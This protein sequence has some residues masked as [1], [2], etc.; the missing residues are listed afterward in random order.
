MKMKGK[1]LDWRFMMAGLVIMVLLSS[2][3][4]V[5][6]SVHQGQMPLRFEISFTGN[7]ASEMAALGLQVP[8]TGRLFVII[9]KDNSSEP[10][11]QINVVGVPFWGKDVWNISADQTIAITGE[12]ASA[13]GYPL[14][15]FADVPS[16]EY[17]VQAF[18]NVYT[19]FHRADGHVIK[20]HLNSGAGQHMWRSP[21]NAYSRTQRLH[22]D[23]ES[24][25]TIALSLSEVIPPNQPLKEG[26]VL[27]Q[28]NYEDTEWVKYVKIKSELVSEFWGQDMYI[29]ANILLPKGYHDHP[30]VYYPVIYLQG[31]FPGGWA[32]FG[33]R[34]G[35]FYDFWTSD[36][37]PRMIAVTFRHANPYYDSSY[38]INSANVGPYGDAI[39]EELIPYIEE[40]FRIIREP[41]ARILAG[42]STGGW[43]ALALQVWYPDFFGGTWSWCPDSVDFHHYQV[44]NIYRDENAY[45]AEYDWVKV[46]RPCCRLPDGNILF[47]IKQESYW[48]RAMGPN[49]LSGAQW[50]IFEAVY[51]PVGEN[52]Y[53]QPIWDPVTGK[54][55]HNVAEYWKENYDI[56]YKLQQ[57]WST[58]GPKLVG[59]IHIATGDMDSYYL[60]EAVYLLR[61]FLE[62]T[63]DPYAE[64]TFD[65]GPHRPHC[66][67]GESPARPGE[68]MTL[69]EF[70]LIV[71]DYLTETAP[72]GDDTSSWKY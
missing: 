41:W 57:D 27:Q 38:T 58:L 72:A 11:E 15:R 49:G 51:G 14:E 69:T 52:G 30:D 7:V 33:F 39:V 16:G 67:I 65:F 24:S 10:R 19:T 70:I 62:S 47:T 43:E 59:K 71:A 26:E 2:G 32:P 36:E 17:Y 54:I 25:G 34:E 3:I 35:D 68:I 44:V 1:R 20:M 5:S 37:A 56:N 23:P 60:N 18:L 29:G 42:G 45:Y 22:L 50:A 4:L 53:A 6:D 8:V 31:H 55:D 13:I 40:H 66:W 9:T 48:E 64:A 63:I 28:G 46:E 61:D 21:G 12:D